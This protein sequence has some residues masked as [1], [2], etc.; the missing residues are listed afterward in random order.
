MADNII[1]T[2]SFNF[3]LRIIKL[4]QFLKDDK[5]EYVLS[6][7]L[8]RSGTA[9]GA[10][11]RES[12]QAESKKDFIHKLAIAQKEA[13]ETDYWLELLFQSNYLNEI[14]FQS[15]KSDIVEINKILASIIITSKQKL[16]TT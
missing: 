3:A 2:K 14:Q 6:K 1:K 7:Q 4:F 16:S 15:V 11:I 8:L 5:K 10:L 12:E 13:N 9:I